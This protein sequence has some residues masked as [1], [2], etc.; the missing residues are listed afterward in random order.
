MSLILWHSETYC[1]ASGV[2]DD[3]SWSETPP[4]WTQLLGKWWLREACRAGVG[5]GN[6]G[7]WQR[8]G[9]CAVKHDRW[10]L[11]ST[12]TAPEDTILPSILFTRSLSSFILLTSPASL[13]ITAH[14]KGKLPQKNSFVFVYST[15]LFD[16]H[17]KPM[18]DFLLWNSQWDI[19]Q[20]V[21][22]VPYVHLHQVLIWF[23]GCTRIVFHA[24]L[25]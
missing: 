15:Q 19:K 20:N 5:R 23:L 1:A 25:F 24:W 4:S 21:R 6:R 9:G 18:T 14:L 22:V 17:F 12:H 3:Q 2:R 11:W 16:L 8:A 7:K 10:S 13:Q